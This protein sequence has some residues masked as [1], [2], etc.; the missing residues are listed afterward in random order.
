MAKLPGIACPGPQTL[1]QKSNFVVNVY[2]GKSRC[3][4]QQARLGHCHPA[5]T[6]RG[7]KENAQHSISCKSDFICSGDRLLPSAGKEGGKRL[8]AGDT[9]PPRRMC[10]TAP[11]AE[12]FTWPTPCSPPSA[13]PPASTGSQEAHLHSA[14]PKPCHWLCGAIYLYRL[15]PKHVL[16][17]PPAHCG[18][19][20]S[21]PEYSI[22]FCPPR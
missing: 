17:S 3:C 2:P 10:P 15:P 6:V 12:L 5:T 14:G 16:R 20:L 11:A 7:I 8:L 4:T 19:A 18:G 21:F 1:S 9:A 22:C 13:S